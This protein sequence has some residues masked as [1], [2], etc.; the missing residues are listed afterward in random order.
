MAKFRSIEICYEAGFLLSHIL[1]VE[2]KSV[3][4][5]VI[6]SSGIMECIH[7]MEDMVQVLG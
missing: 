2:D 4:K 3:S 6:R 1:N 7:T 5:D